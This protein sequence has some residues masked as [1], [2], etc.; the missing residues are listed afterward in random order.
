MSICRLMLLVLIAVVGCN[1]PYKRSQ[2]ALPTTP[3][4][5]TPLLP[6]P[7][8]PSPPSLVPAPPPLPAVADTPGLPDPTTVS[9]GHV[10]EADDTRRQDRQK[11]RQERREGPRPPEPTTPAPL[12]KPTEPTPASGPAPATSAPPSDKEAVAKLVDAASARWATVPDFEA[13]LVKR[14]VA[15]GK[16]V[17]QSEVLYRFRQSPHSVYMKVVGGAGEGREVLYVQGKFGDKMHV[18]T[19]KGD[20]LLVGVGFKTEM[21]PHDKQA[22]AKSRYKVTEAGFGRTING[23]KKQLDA[24][25]AG[26]AVRSL[27]AVTRPEHPYP[28]DGVEVVCKPG[29][30]PTLPKGGTRQVFFDPKPESPSYRLP[31]LVVCKEPDG[32]EVEYYSF[33]RFKSPGGW[34]DG[35]WNP[36]RL[37][38]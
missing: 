30:D 17:P 7:T 8:P 26:V 18:V 1:R 33:D 11:R 12:P 27:G 25:E 10:E 24:K 5:P 13:R 23:L 34:Q 4:E 31:V 29:D 3:P 2:P 28:L 22:T 38:K 6:V 9:A 16:V 14:E 21:D 36:G 15:N 20:N 37:K 32:R 19:G 35:D